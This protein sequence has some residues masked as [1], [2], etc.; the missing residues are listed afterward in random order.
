M[1]IS[2]RE[3]LET[4]AAGSLAAGSLMADSGTGMPTRVLGKTGARVSILAMGGGSRFL[5]YDEGQ[6]AEAVHKALDLGVT[7]I[8]TSDDYG[9][10]HLSERRIGAAIKGRRDRIFL[11]TKVSTRVP[12][13]VPRGVELSLQSLQVDH[14]DLLH[15]HSI[16]EEDDLARVEAKG[17][18]LDQVLKLRDQKIARF[19]GITSHTNPAVLAK[20]LERHDFD[21]TQMALNAGTVAMM[22]GAGG[23]MVPNPAMKASFETLALPVA[24]RKKMGILG[25]KVFAQDAL[26]GQASAGKLLYYTLSLPITAAVVSMPK[27]EHIEENT[28]LAKAFRP[29]S[30]VEMKDLSGRL[31][32]KNKE[33]LDRFFRNHVDA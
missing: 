5:L 26:I 9:Q 31:S 19:I 10:N 1:S 13:E 17:G 20:A 3:F 25:M 28:K 7:Y 11:A 32:E 23:K 24:V 8:D 12:D 18:V 14:V 29:L 2:R 27:L 6:A 15:I 33:A 30:P 16:T 21:C 4:A 22:S